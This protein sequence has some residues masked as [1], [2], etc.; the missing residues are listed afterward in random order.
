MARSGTMSS[1]PSGF[2][3]SSS[4]T[5]TAIT[6]TVNPM[7]RPS[8]IQILRRDELCRAWR[9]ETARRHES[10]YADPLLDVLRARGFEPETCAMDRGY[11]KNRVMDETRVGIEIP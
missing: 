10:L 2:P 6:A 3:V 9:V 8:I 5:T 7:R 4:H 1:P 11:D